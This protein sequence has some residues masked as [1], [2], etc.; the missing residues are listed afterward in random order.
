MESRKPR[1]E[2]LAGMGALAAAASFPEVLLSARARLYPSADLSPLE[3]PRS[4]AGADSMNS[5]FRVAVINDEVSQDFGRSC[6]VISREFG[7]G[8]I[9]L[10]GMWN[11][12]LLH[13]DAKEVAEARRI[14]EKYKLRV[15]DIG[16]LTMP[17]IFAA[18]ASG[19]ACRHHAL[20]VGCKR[21]GRATIAV[22]GTVFDAPETLGLRN[23]R[24]DVDGKKRHAGECGQ[25]GAND[26]HGKAPKN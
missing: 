2:F 7:L 16:S 13:L 4:K 24:A 22:A 3:M 1:R 11:K 9:E 19:P 25:N 17:P 8:W 10:R 18:M 26:K 6:E 5:P 23:A 15:T 20:F 21:A 14:L 12:N